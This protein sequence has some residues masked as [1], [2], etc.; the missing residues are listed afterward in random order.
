VAVG[1]ALLGI[2]Y[3]LI[4]RNLAIRDHAAAI[5]KEERERFRVTLRS[6]GDGVIVTD[7]EDRVIFMNEVAHAL[8]DWDEE[9]IGQGLSQVFRI[10]HEI[11]DDGAELRSDGSAVLAPAKHAILVGKH[12]VRIPIDEST[13][14]VRDDRGAVL[15]AI[16]VFR[17]VTDRRQEEEER[18]R[19]DA[20]KDEFLAMLGHELRSPL[21]AVRNAI[22]AAN[23]D[24]SVRER[25]LEIARRQTSRLTRLVDDLLDVARISRRK[26][27]LR[28]ERISLNEVV[29]RAVETARPLAQDRGHVLSISYPPEPIEVEAD[30]IRLEQVVDNLFTNAIKYTPPGGRIALG[31]TRHG[32][33]AVVS[34]SD[35]GVGI[36]GELLP[37]IFDLFVQT[38]RTLDRADGGLGI[39]LTIVK[40][41]VELHGGSVEARSDGPGKGAEFTFRL[42]ALEPVQE[43]APAL[44]PA[45]LRGAAP[46]LV[47]EDNVD[48]ADALLLLLAIAGF[49][50]HVAHDGREALEMAKAESYGLVFVDIGLPGIDGYEVAKRLREIPGYAAT[51]LVALTGYGRDEDR[52][53]ALREGF[54]LHLVKPVEMETL[55]PLLARL[56]R[57]AEAG[58]AAPG[59]AV[60]LVAVK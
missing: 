2:I 7:S 10:E 16:L 31:A 40:L 55:E 29:Q 26:I 34:V 37:R 24:E 39:G 41:L 12:G 30:A 60:K 28:K 57:P 54:A 32:S 15:G 48:A 9:A 35:S 5:V 11:Q 52:E 22:A 20:A 45:M 13:A 42:P 53:R 3:A 18:R 51:Y 6:I 19:A 23:L 8:T 47:V 36:S 17:D 46:V 25:A 21:A 38:E 58:A 1:L 43:A 33:E 50:A 59:G 56:E 14:P 44:P 49:E 4:R 27:V